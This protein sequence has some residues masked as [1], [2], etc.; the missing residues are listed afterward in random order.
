MSQLSK[1]PASH[2]DERATRSNSRIANWSRMAI[3]A[4]AL[5]A[6]PACAPTYSHSFP[7]QPEY[8][9][10][11]QTQFPQNTAQTENMEPQKTTLAEPKNTSP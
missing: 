10:P 5:S 3:F 4:S 2:E 6:T 7:T 8:S 1:T 9:Q 11:T